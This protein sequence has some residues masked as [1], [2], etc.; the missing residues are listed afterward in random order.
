MINSGTSPAVPPI[1]G[2]AGTPYWTNREIIETQDVPPSLLVLGGGAIG[3]ELAQ[4][5]AR[6][7]SQVTIVEAL[8]QL[9][10][11]EEP[12]SRRT[13]REGLHGRG[14]DREHRRQR[15]VSQS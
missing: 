7:G 2:L 4:V 5:F 12:E 3:A 1:P 10:P 9:L 14:T 11:L 13:A 15:V 6:F 8:G